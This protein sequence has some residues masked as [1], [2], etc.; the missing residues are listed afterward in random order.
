MIRSGWSARAGLSLALLLTPL[1]GSSASGQPAPPAPSAAAALALIPA[2][3]SITLAAGAFTLNG[4]TDI[5][6][7]HDLRGVGTLFGQMLAP[8]TGFPL[9]LRPQPAPKTN[10]ILMVVDG[11]LDRLGQEGYL[12]EITPERV[13]IRVFAPAGAFYATQTLRQLL[14]PAA[15]G[16]TRAEGPWTL[17]ALTIEDVPRFAWRGLMLDAVRHFIPKTEVLKFIDLLA[18]HKM[19]TLHWHLTDDQGWRLEIKKYPLLT[20]VGA[21]RKETRVGHELQAQGFDGTPHTGFYTQGDIREVVAY[22]KARFVTIVPEIDMPGHA[23]A[24][25]AA[26]PDL[27]V[28]R[29]KLAVS[30]RWGVHPHLFDPGEQTTQFLQDVLSE[31]LTLFPGRFVHIGGDE[32][33]LDEWKASASVQARIKALGLKDERALQGHLI[34]QMDAFLT[35][36]GRRLIG[37]DEIL[38]GGVGASATIMSWRGADRA[39]AAARAGHDVV[40]TPET[41]LYF[42]RAQAASADE[43]LA[44]ASEVTPVEAVYAFDPAPATLPPA[45]ARRVLGAQGQLWTEYIATPAQLEYMAF[46]RAAALAEVTWSAKEGRSFDDFRARMQPHEARLKTLGVHYRPMSGPASVPASR[47]AP[48]PDA[49]REP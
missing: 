15:F 38:D 31:V 32:A 22:A 29:E 13:V 16:T 42:D 49:A 8:A 10:V 19:N 4:G 28:T 48:K 35:R 23:Q 3:S 40:M 21:T 39:R 44:A 36:R 41:P 24:A 43:P 30:T 6:T 45:E 18:L 12:L 25:L 47:P 5:V 9:R 33:P 27:G 1:A 11:T 7:D 26:Y 14:P 20:A 46:P 37:W 34:Q 2:P 17:P